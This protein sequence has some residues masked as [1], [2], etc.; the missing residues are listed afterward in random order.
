M[1]L[2]CIGLSGYGLDILALFVLISAESIIIGLVYFM[3]SFD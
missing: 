1:V 3:L 2:V